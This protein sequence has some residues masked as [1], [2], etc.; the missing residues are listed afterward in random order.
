MAP[1]EIS[2]VHSGTNSHVRDGIVGDW[3]VGG[4]IQPT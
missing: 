4:D 2:S 3:G 1:R